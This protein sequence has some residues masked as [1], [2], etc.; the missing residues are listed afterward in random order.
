MAG[1]AYGFEAGYLN[2]YQS[3]LAKSEGGHCS[4]PLTRTDWYV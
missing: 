1:S 4:L 2:V 3:L